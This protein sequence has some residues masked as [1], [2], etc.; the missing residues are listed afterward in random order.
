MTG[1][2]ELFVV[3][4]TLWPL[5]QGEAP[6]TTTYAVVTAF[7]TIYVT[8][9][10]DV[11][12]TI[13]TWQISRATSPLK[14][15]YCVKDIGVANSYHKRITLFLWTQWW[16]EP[17]L[18]LTFLLVGNS[19]F[20]LERFTKAPVELYKKSTGVTFKR[21]QIYS[22]RRVVR[23]YIFLSKAQWCAS[24]GGKWEYELST[25]GSLGAVALG[26]MFQV[27]KCSFK[28]TERVLFTRAFVCRSHPGDPLRHGST[29]F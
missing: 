8:Y 6:L 4:Y 27:L 7:S 29:W 17:L 18:P 24:A 1:S 16:C 19:F 2:S 25:L 14:N 20:T 9:C 21:E 22:R 3:Q 15:K 13:Y 26:M 11:V 10:T 12:R 28:K 23:A 5:L